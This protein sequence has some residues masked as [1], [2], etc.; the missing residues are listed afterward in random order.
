M[1]TDTKIRGLK[2]RS[3]RYLVADGGGLAIEIR[4]TGGKTWVYRYR[5]NGKPEKVTLGAYPEITLAEARDLHHEARRQVERGVSPALSK[6]LAAE[7]A[8]LGNTVADFA[9]NWFVDYG[10]QSS[11]SWR[12]SVRRWLD[13]DVIPGLGRYKIA[14]VTPRDILGLLDNIKARGATVSALRVRVILKQIFDAAKARQAILANPVSEIPSKIVGKLKP[15]ERTLSPT[16][17]K[18]FFSDLQNVAAGL[19]RNKIALKI[20]THTLCRK[21]ELGRAKWQD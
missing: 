14:D 7:E 21:M 4:P 17:L 18:D 16:E 20:I 11:P 5:I 3:Q 9:E 8:R 10:A 13:K 1:L 6:R 12:H 19:P 15:R 2:P